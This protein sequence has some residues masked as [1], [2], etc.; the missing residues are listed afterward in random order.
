MNRMRSPAFSCAEDA[1]LKST[2]RGSPEESLSAGP[3][4]HDEPSGA[5]FVGGEAI[6]EEKATIASV[7][8]SYVQYQREGR[9]DCH[10]F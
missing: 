6:I 8:L 10:I 7:Q 9:T 3:H 2:L 5:V 4:G 1:A